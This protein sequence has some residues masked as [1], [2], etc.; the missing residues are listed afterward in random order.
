MNPYSARLRDTMADV[1]HSWLRDVFTTV[2]SR[3]GIDVSTET[4]RIDR[5][6]AD[7]ARRL[8]ADIDELLSH[9]AWEQRRN[10]LDLV[11]AAMENV[12]AELKRMGARPVSRDEFKERSFP[13]DVFDLAPATWSDL[14][15]DLHEPGLE[16]GAWKA[17]A[18][19]SHRRSIEGTSS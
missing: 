2:V 5:V 8:L 13:D 1:V 17:A 18:I 12:T 10:P 16:W 11:R 4:D 19:M 9:E 15:P 7:T 14:H 3:Q 6:V